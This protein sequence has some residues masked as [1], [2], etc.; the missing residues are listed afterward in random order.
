[1]KFS[2]NQKDLQE[3]LG[4]CQN[5]I[6]RRSTLPILSNVLLQAKEKT[7]KITATDLDM[8]F[9]HNISNVEIIEEGETTTNSSIMHDI[10]RKFSAGK[11]IN[12]ET[13]SESKLQLESEKSIFKLNCIDSK[14]FPLSDDDL[15]G[16]EIILNS[17][18]FLKLLNKCKFSI[19]ND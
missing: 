14:E 9:V 6:E 15:N 4:F 16:E 19:S 3:S 13:I 11:K 18:S 1:M 8:I 2:I 5:V 17:Q 12:V 10:V 7:I